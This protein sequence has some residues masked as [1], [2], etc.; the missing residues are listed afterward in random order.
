MAASHSYG[1][2]GIKVFGLY[3]N[4]YK[5]VYHSRNLLF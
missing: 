2:G 3:G 4:G 1:I 5:P